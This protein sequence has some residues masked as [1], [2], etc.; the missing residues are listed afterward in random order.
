MTSKGKHQKTSGKWNPPDP[1][2][3]EQI[4]LDAA[5]GKIDDL[6]RE[7]WFG[8]DQK[9]F[10]YRV[11]FLI[12]NKRVIIE[13]DGRANHLTET[14]RV[15]DAKRQRYLE[16]SG[17]R[18]IRF[19]GTEI[20]RDANQCV[21]EVIGF[22]SDL[23][24]QHLDHQIIYI[25]RIFLYQQII[26]SEMFYKALYPSKSLETPSLEELV[27]HMIDWL[28]FPASDIEVYIFQLEESGFFADVM[29]LHGKVQLHKE[30]RIRYQV[31]EG[32]WIAFEILEHLKYHAR[33]YDG[34]VLVADDPLYAD[35]LTWVG[36]KKPAYLLRRDNDSTRMV[37]H[38]LG[39]LKWQNVQ[40][41][42]G[43]AMGLKVPEL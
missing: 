14:D 24:D 29:N 22:L 18:V 30:S 32:E 43:S 9:H 8:D 23:G 36:N 2:P 26:Q 40:Y 17:Y 35:F 11:D 20:T 33:Y 12:K 39:R 1:T 28:H 6:A 21:E 13:L 31:F 10:R 38:G 3:I 37:H 4:F 15:N 5:N 19:T 41:I 42:I 34:F 27:T 16:R 25:D 7:E